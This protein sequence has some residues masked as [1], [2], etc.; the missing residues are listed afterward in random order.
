[1]AERKNP[2][3]WIESTSTQIRWTIVCADGT[4][5]TG[6]D[7]GPPGITITDGLRSVLGHAIR[8][9]EKALGYKLLSSCTVHLDSDDD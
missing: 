7:P 6:T 9:M 3:I 1:M 2:E 4:V 8:E 5:R